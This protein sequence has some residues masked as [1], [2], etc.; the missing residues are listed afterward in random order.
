[1]SEYQATIPPAGTACSEDGCC[2]V[3]VVRVTM[4]AQAAAGGPPDDGQ[5]PAIWDACE[6]HWPR[7]RAAYIRAG[8]VI[9]DATG[10]PAD[11]KL[12]YPGWALWTSVDAG[13]LY[14]TTRTPGGQG[15]TVYACLVGQLRAQIDQA[16]AERNAA[17][18][19]SA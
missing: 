18:A 4:P 15:M 8:H 11:I 3:A 1:M 10:D 13:R 7:L 17:V 19:D 16:L 14:A 9:A 12:D 2:S 5:Q 6:L